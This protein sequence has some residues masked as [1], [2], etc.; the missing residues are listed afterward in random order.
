MDFF[1]F[2]YKKIIEFQAMAR[3]LITFEINQFNVGP[4]NTLCNDIV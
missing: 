3:N 4:N 1:F 2:I